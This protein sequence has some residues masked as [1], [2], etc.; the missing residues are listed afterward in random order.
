[1]TKHWGTT[2][3]GATDRQVFIAIGY[4]SVQADGSDFDDVRY[5]YAFDDPDEAMQFV[6]WAQ[7]HND[8]AVD[9]WEIVTEVMRTAKGAYDTHRAWVED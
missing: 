5:L 7:S 3:M 4:E 9:R 8:D 6:E 1:M 2:P